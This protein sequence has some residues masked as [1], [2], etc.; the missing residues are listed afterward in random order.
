MPSRH[1]P[2]PIRVPIMRYGCSL[3][4]PIRVATVVLCLLFGLNAAG[5]A[6]LLG[7]RAPAAAP[8]KPQPEAQEREDDVPRSDETLTGDPAEPASEPSAPVPVAEPTW[9]YRVQLYSFTDRERAEAALQQVKRTLA[10][11]SYGVYLVEES[12]SFKV[13][14]G[15]FMEKDDADILRDWLRNRGFVDAWTARTLIQTR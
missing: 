4:M 2:L 15:D 11:W 9:G 13:R 3:K 1:A 12:N 6:W 14:V 10:E 5:C 8:Q 7:K